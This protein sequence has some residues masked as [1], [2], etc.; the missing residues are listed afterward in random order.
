MYF[1]EYF[2]VKK[3]LIED[4][5]AIDINLICDLPLFID[6]MLIFNSQKQEYVDLHN[7]I[8]KYFHFLAK[9]SEQGLNT[10]DISTFFD[11]VK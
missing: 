7:N 10:G 2:E 9:K 4:Y 3:Q 5:G 8:I 6:P 11:F 1:S